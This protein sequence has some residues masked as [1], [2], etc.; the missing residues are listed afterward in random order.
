MSSINSYQFTPIV[1]TSGNKLS[2]KIRVGRY[3][4]EDNLP[5]TSSTFEGLVSN[6][7]VC[8]AI[9]TSVEG[10]G[11]RTSLFPTGSRVPA[12]AFERSS[13]ST[14]GCEIPGAFRAVGWHLGGGSHSPES[15]MGTSVSACQIAPAL[16]AAPAHDAKVARFR[17]PSR[18]GPHR[19]LGLRSV[20]VRGSPA[21]SAPL[22]YHWY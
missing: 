10:G 6:R 18:Q 21:F 19:R 16:V 7:V 14:R 1:T 15:S 2:H 5:T 17:M 8:C 20:R 13:N 22:P 3:A 11:V 9:Q 12:V 4:P